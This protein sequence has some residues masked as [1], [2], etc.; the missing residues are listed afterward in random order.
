MKFIPQLRIAQK[1]PLALVGS[2]LVVSAGVGIASYLIGLG[3]VRDQRDQSMQASLNTASALVSDYYSGA[4]VD[5]RLFVQR[6]DTVTAM[7]NLTRSL[8]ELRM[9][10]KERAALQLQTAYVT[11]SPN[12]EDRAAVDSVGAMGASYDPVHKRYHPGFRTLQLERD[13]S[14]VLMISAAGDVVYSVAKNT[15][16]A[17]NV[18]TDTTA[19]ASG[20]GQAFA[21]AKDL[22][23]GQA[24][25]V[26][27]S[28]YGPTGTPESF[29]AMPVFDKDEKTGVMVLAISPDVMS[30]A[31]GGL[32]GLGRSGEVVVVGQDGLLRSE[33]PRTEAPDVLATTLTSDVIAGAFAGETGEGISTDYRGAPMVV[34]AQAVSVGDVTWAVAAVQPEDEA[35]A[36]VVQMRNMTIMVG[37]ILLAIAAVVGFFFARSISRPIS[38]LTDTMET[39]AS[40]ELDVEVQG[41]RRADEIGAMARAV[42][43]FRENALKVH[44]MTEAEAARIVANQAERA[45][46][47]Q[48]LQRAFGQVVDAAIAGDFSRRVT[49]EFPDDELNTLARSV[50]ELV[51]TVDRGV[52]ETGSVLASLANTDLTQRMQGDYQGAFARLKVD[53]NAVADKLADIVGQLRDTSRTLKTATGEILS[54][55]NDLSERTTKQAATIEETSAAMEQ[56]A[57][58]VLAN[59]DRAKEASTVATSVTHTAEQGGQVMGE[60]TEAMERIT[61]SSAKISNIIGLIDDIAFQTNLLALN[62]SVEAARAGEAGKG[63]AVVAVEV[64]R[65]A[66]S[67]AQASSDVKALI[68]QSAEEVKGGSKLVA[69]AASRLEEILASARSSSELMNGIARESRE[70]ASSID[71]VNTA[72]RTM[73]EMT[74]HNAAL[75]E[76]M[77]ASIEQT[78][79][80]ASQLDRIVD[81]FAL[82]ER[83]AVAKEVPAPVAKGPVQAISQ[84]ARGL[85]AKLSTAAKSYLSKGNA[86]VDTDWSEF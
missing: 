38:R 23:E 74:Q 43:I 1:L 65:L 27:F 44:E 62:A 84:G 9:G 71:E 28:L 66:Q 60:A 61:Q 79:A 2:A 77:N 81:I 64:R 57:S 29:M 70:Q 11:D 32:S 72:V 53:T 82:E 5:L 10:L 18:V 48:E 33:S 24:A 4:E 37:G 52:S 21:M 63:F 20:L 30:D 78:E 51:E 17:T 39:L 50:N 86:A 14:D 26:D 83:A 8:D 31:V 59:A 54:G 36:A 34:R 6:S 19:A 55:A 35:Y 73:D 12:P 67:A 76:E 49:A 47:M 41:E 25:F 85:Q 7:K 13:Y 46:M 75:V 40:G 15:D 58:T 16:F 56:L 80:Q 42:E 68:E 22:T 45:A 69:D 3:T